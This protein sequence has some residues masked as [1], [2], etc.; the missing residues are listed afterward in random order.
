MKPN[1]SEV[2][3]REAVP[4]DA[5]KLIEYV[6][7][8]SNEPGIHLELSP[9]D[10]TLTVE[11]EQDYI[12]RCAA[13]ENSLFLV[14]EHD[15]EIIGSL[16]CSGSDRKAIRHVTSLGISIAADF[17]NQ[18]IGHLMLAWVINWAR[19]TGIV[20]RIHLSVFERNK[21]AIHLYRKFGFLV[22]GQRRNAIFRNGEYQDTLIM[23]LIL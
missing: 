15:S 12:R 3:I 17:R 5:E 10:F 22:E 1:P 21:P 16:T 9:G 4:E 13:S 19:G 8:I 23:A 18:G 20:T 11:E 7:H 6:H 2:T 14:A